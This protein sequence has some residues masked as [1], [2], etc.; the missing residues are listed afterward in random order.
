MAHTAQPGL[1]LRLPHDVLVDLFMQLEPR[2]LG[3][4]P[5]TCRLLHYGQSS[6][7][8]PKPLEN[9]L[10]HR[11]TLNGWSRTLPVDSCEAVKYFTRL[12]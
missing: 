7:Q 5:S 9:A 4:L 1:L 10:R 3:R 11:A 8:T 6:P 2:D 12:A